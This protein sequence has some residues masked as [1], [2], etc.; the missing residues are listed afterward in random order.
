MPNSKR[1]HYVHKNN[2]LLIA[3]ITGAVIVW[4]V[5]Y[6]FL[7][8]MTDWFVD[9][10]LDMAPAAKLTDTVHFFVFEYPKVMLL[11]LLIIFF[12]GIIGTFFT[13]ERTRKA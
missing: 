2:N 12:I 10:L 11:L 4:V 5:I 13:P 8:P 3:L 9:S 1:T 6:H 7:Q